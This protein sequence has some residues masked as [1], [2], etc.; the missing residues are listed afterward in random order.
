MLYVTTTQY[1]VLINGN[2]EGPIVPTR[3]LRQGNPLSPYLFIICTEG[4]SRLHQK[5]EREGNIHGI[6]ITRGAPPITHLFFADDSLLFFKATD[7][8]AIEVK[9]CLHD[10]GRLSGQAINF[11]KS[12]ITFSKDTNE[13]DKKRISA[14]FNVNQTEDYGKYLGLP[15][16]IG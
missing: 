2:L 12:C 14:I 1:N 15:T 4:L 10:Y 16:V 8:E 3:G 6:S 13:T 7:Q 5:A 11:H 9:R